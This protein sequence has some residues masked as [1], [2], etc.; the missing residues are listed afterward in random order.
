M[1]QSVFAAVSLV[2]GTLATSAATVPLYVNISP[3]H[4]PPDTPPQI[5]AIAFANQSIFEV[6]DTTGAGLPYQTFNTWYFTNMP[7]S[8]V[9][10]GN[11]GFRFDHSTGSTRLPMNYWVNQ[12]SITGGVFLLISAT[13]ISNSGRLTTSDRGLIRLVGNNIN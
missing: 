3:V 13:N 4:S 8:A 12:G 9:M 7:S 6:N 2:I 10:Y 11:V 1:R 5:D